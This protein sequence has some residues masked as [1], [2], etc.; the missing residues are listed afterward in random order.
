MTEREQLQ[1]D[2]DALRAFMDRRLKEP[3][4]RS[5]TVYNAEAFDDPDW[6]EVIGDE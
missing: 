6:P 1:E 3:N 5:G 2:V 4:G